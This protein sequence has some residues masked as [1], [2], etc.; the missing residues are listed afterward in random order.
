ME[1]QDEIFSPKHKRLLDIATWAKW[2]AWVM[3]ILGIIYAGTS[4]F[5]VYISIM[6]G[7]QAGMRNWTFSE[8]LPQFMKNPQLFIQFSYG[9]VRAIIYYLVLKGASLGLNMIVETDINYREK[10]I[11]EGDND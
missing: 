11:V 5:G 6:M 2:L 10:S 8:F 7:Q 1:T 9:I 4:T 3:L